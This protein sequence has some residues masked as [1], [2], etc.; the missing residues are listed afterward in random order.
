MAAQRTTKRYNVFIVDDDQFLLDMYTLKFT[1]AGCDVEGIP[2]S[3]QAL[4]KFRAGACPDVLILDLVMPE[5]DGLALLK[6]IRDESL[7]SNM[8]IIVLSNQ[9]QDSDV[10]EARKYDID[11]YI[12][13]ASTVPSEVLSQVL[14]IADKKFA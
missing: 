8:A 1:E 13:K 6:S 11:G 12:I 4:E 9:G 7:C 14:E 5:I 2:G 10:E 3:A